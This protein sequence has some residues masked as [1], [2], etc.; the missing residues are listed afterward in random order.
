MG[1]WPCSERIRCF[2]PHWTTSK[3]RTPASQTSYSCIYKSR[4]LAQ[5]CGL[6]API[7]RL[8]MNWV[9]T[10]TAF[11]KCPYELWFVY[12]SWSYS[13]LLGPWPLCQGLPNA[14]HLVLLYSCKRLILPRMSKWMSLDRG[15]WSHSHFPIP[16]ERLVALDISP[17]LDMFPHPYLFHP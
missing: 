8:T 13:Q 15:R 4:P 1:I 12:E 17:Q 10:H 3:M 9:F 11:I 14:V 7:L 6:C 5:L 16:I 2:K